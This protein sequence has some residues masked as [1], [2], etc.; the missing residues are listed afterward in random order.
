[1]SF[2]LA[3]SLFLALGLW[4]N[5]YTSPGAQAVNGLLIL[6]QQELERNPVHY[7]HR[8]WVLYPGVLLTPEEV[9]PDAPAHDMVY[10]DIDTRTQFD[11]GDGRHRCSRTY[12]MRLQL[13][14]ER[15]TY[16]L[17]LPEVFSAYR[18]YIG[19]R[20]VLQMGDPEPGT[21]QD[22]IQSRMVTFEAAGST[23][24]LLAV[25]DRSH[26][27][28]GLVCPPAFGDPQAV[29]L[30]RGRR[31]GSVLA[32]LVTAVLA[33]GLSL[34]LCV[35][36][37]YRNAL[38]FFL[39]CLSMA[40]FIS[41]PLVHWAWA[42]PVFPWYSLELTCGYAVTLLL[43]IL[44]NRVCKVGRAARVASNGLAALI[45]LLAL[46]YGLFSA[47]LTG[48]VIR[49]FGYTELL[50]EL[51]VAAYLFVSAY[52]SVARRESDAAPMFYATVI[53]A[54]AF[55]WDK[56]LPHFEPISFG[57][58]QEWGSLCLV[59][60]VGYTLWRDLVGNYALRLTLAE[61]HRQVTRQLAI[62]QAHYLTLTEKI[63]VSTRYQHDARHHLQ[64]LMRL[65]EGGKLEELQAYLGS[66]A[67]A[68]EAI[69]WRAMCKHLVLDAILQY[70]SG[71]CQRDGIRFAVEQR[72][73]VPAELPVSGA[74]LSIVCGNLIENA[75]EACV[76]L[77]GRHP[78]A[79]TFIRIYLGLRQGYFIFRVENSAAQHPQTRGGRYLSSKHQGFGI[80]TE[81]V[82][83][84]VERTGGQCR[85]DVGEGIFRASVMMG[86]QE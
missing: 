51:A 10:T 21:Y 12:L 25:S 86:R 44:H 38:L 55:L 17:E 50:Y 5:K 56:L 52:R 57:W 32:V 11:L 1:M 41:D 20:L 69:K 30:A 27:F 47:Q 46:C 29:E 15:R 45:C 67:P 54:S 16:A 62:Q 22:K 78:G 26:F 13:P 18:L 79:A 48:A 71:L 49:L 58:F 3:S 74:D 31:L 23:A 35:S 33:G 59:G 14:E 8:D 84:V 7:L 73:P 42:L 80:G 76:A 4:D 61:E 19:G 70:Y 37:N 24:I 77:R 9:G 43:V 66:Y 28:S 72:E 68:G 82:R 39:L 83:T 64:T 63:D 85:F 81:S 6:S 40:G 2:A 36:M 53:Y 75:H 65:A 34:Y 60:A